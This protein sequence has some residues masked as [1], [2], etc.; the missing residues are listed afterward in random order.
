MRWRRVFS[1]RADQVRSARVFASALFAG[2]GREDDVA[3][4]VAELA[5]N[6]VRHSRSG[7]QR[8]WFG[9]EV[10]MADVAYVAVT[11]QGGGRVPYLQAERP[12]ESLQVS[13]RGLLMVSRLAL[14]TGMHGSPQ[15]GYTVWADMDLRGGGHATTDSDREV[16]LVS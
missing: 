9:L 4:V 16:S 13:G 11:D 5:T 14:A 8:G 2:T 3:V 6:A 10:T 7:T 12:D 15:V 1:G